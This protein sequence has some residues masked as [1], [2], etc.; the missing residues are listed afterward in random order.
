MTNEQI[1]FEVIK[2]GLV[3]IAALF[4][5]YNF[6]RE[7]THRQRIEFDIDLHDL[8]A[9]NSDRV[10]E[11]GALADNKGNVEQ[12]FNSMR[13]RI[14]GIDKNSKLVELEKHK[15][16]LVF[17]IDLKNRWEMIPKKYRPYFVRPGVKQRFPMVLK[18][19]AEWTHILVKITFKYHGTEN[20][21]VS[22]RAFQI[23]LGN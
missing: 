18:I 23:D 9:R 13:L 4:T 14:R 6:F 15:P 20:I 2:I 22:E 8:G 1:I 5:Y 16:R 11:I 17:P 7:G 19:P 21:H 12:K 10:I 3:V